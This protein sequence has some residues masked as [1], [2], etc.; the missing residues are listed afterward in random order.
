M[1]D[2]AA[3]A[4]TPRSAADNDENTSTAA[5]AAKSGTA[6]TGLT[7]A[8]RRL[9]A[10]T[11]RNGDAAAMDH[12]D[13]A[14]AAIR[15]DLPEVPAKQPARASNA[16]KVTSAAAEGPPPP[17]TA[18]AHPNAAAGSPDRAAAAA[19]YR[20]SPPTAGNSN[21]NVTAT[22]DTGGAAAAKSANDAER[23]K[24]ATGTSKSMTAGADAVNDS[25]A[26]AMWA[27]APSA[28]RPMLQ[29]DI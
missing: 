20:F 28:A 22:A 10:A 5:G 16:D 21:C 23:A 25:D 7:K 15:S 27:A 8:S 2:R 26:R 17:T 4:A 18:T 9:T 14:A 11:T 6:G 12:R 3:A 1:A 13:A 29:A 24:G 19:A